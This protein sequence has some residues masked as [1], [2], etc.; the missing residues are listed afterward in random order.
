M[1][2][3]EQAKK[4]SD[5]LDNLVSDYAGDKYQLVIFNSMWAKHLRKQ[6][7]F[8][9]QP[10]S[11]VIKAALLQILR[12]EVTGEEILKIS[13][14]ETVAAADEKKTFSKKTEFKLAEHAG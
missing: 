5:N 10:H 1:T 4:A 3:K 6:E 9:H 11:E 14:E 13:A 12:G 8:R 7:E 2:T